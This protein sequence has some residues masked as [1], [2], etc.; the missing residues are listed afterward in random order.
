MLLR[1]IQIGW[2]VVLVAAVPT[3]ALLVVVAQQARSHHDAAHQAEAELQRMDSLEVVSRIQAANVFPELSVVSRSA[4]A[5]TSDEPFAAFIVDALWDTAISRYLVA[6][7]NLPDID[8]PSTPPTADLQVELPAALRATF[9]AQRAAVD[10]LLVARAEGRAP[11]PDQIALIERTRA[12]AD[13]ALTDLGRAGSSDA[14]IVHVAKVDAVRTSW[15]EYVHVA[16]TLVG[17]DVAD[18]D[19]L[20]ELAGRRVQATERVVGVVPADLRQDVE[21]VFD[22]PAYAEWT[23]ASD[24]ARAIARGDIEPWTTVA[25]V[26]HL[27][28]AVGLAVEIDAL[29]GAAVDE[30]RAAV[31]ADAD[32]ATATRNQLL[33][34]AAVLVSV[35]AVLTGLLLAS[36]VRPIRI[37]TNRA[38]SIARGEHDAPSTPVGGRD[39]LTE[40]GTVLDDVADGLRHLN[41]Q[42]AAIAAGR[43]DDPDLDV[44][45]PGPVGTFVQRRLD[46]LRETSG[47]LRTDAG[48]D[49]LT[50]LLNRRGLL[51]QLRRQEADP[52]QRLVVYVDLD[53]FKGVNDRHGHRHG[54]AVL[55]AVARRL[56]GLVRQGDPVCRIGGDEFVL[57][58]DEPGPSA[59]AAFLERIKVD[60]QRPVEI[61]GQSHRIGCSA[62]TAALP[63]GDDVAEALDR[64][65]DE[66]DRR[67]L[68]DKAL[69]GRRS[70]LRVGPD[71]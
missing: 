12:E 56:E 22:S 33:V 16:P 52:R 18:P 11:T 44:A 14:W 15:I 66:A 45:A 46:D 40:L 36:V 48:T 38:A 30:T 70:D 3:L 5:S 8:E 54:D 7:A 26:G 57:V 58:V 51:D 69:S 24:T 2:R 35:T 9:E 49:P 55:I 4:S 34:I 10:E 13:L 28:G 53:R 68:D 59:I 17:L 19:D 23:A 50:G 20:A 67:M 25:A 37:L 1:S 32:T 29:A 71:A 60:L 27:A 43:L 6:D 42:V 65:L 62:G 47:A 39:E 41:H 63:A 61:E 64:A 31:S 21:V